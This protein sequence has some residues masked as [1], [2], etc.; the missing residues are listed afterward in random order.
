MLGIH[1]LIYVPDYIDTEQHRC[2]IE[3]ID[4]QPWRA[5]LARRT[6]HYGYVYDYR[7]K[8]VDPSMCVPFAWEPG[9]GERLVAA[10][11]QQDL[12]WDALE[13]MQRLLKAPKPTLGQLP[14]RTMPHCMD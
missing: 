6:Q 11:H 12:A 4:A 14:Q 8:T 3:M 5:D 9:N 10:Q 2:L 7:A 1:G 13:R